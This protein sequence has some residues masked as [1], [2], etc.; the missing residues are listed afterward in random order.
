MI[1][2]AESVPRFDAE[3]DWQIAQTVP[4]SA[5]VLLKKI[6]PALACLLAGCG[7]Q[8]DPTLEQ[9]VEQTYKVEPTVNISVGNGDGSISI[10][11]ADTD[12]VSVEAT[13]R[14]YS[15]SRLNGIA[16][17]VST[18]PGFIAIETNFPPKP[19]WGLFD[20]SG[21]VDYV[22]IVPR[23]AKIS[24]LDLANGEILVEEMRGAPVQARLGSGRF[25]AHNCFCN[26]HVAVV[27]G[28]L[29]VIYDWWEETK[30]S[31]DANIADGNASVSLP[32]DASFHL[33]AE[34]PGGK[35]A[36]DFAE[37]EERNGSEV[38][39]IDKMIGAAPS[40]DIKI[41]A[42]DGNIQILERNP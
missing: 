23:T 27:R 32:D 34:A 18:Q 39:K 42:T 7:S 21:I 15:Q 30:F 10:Y 17:N 4:R 31:V 22:L 9:I 24:R 14:A 35:I 40:A 3:D 1:L 20:R 16:V 19:T 38:T 25:S 33:I 5:A 36:N 41:H 37:R 13:K 29:S 28:L 8:D 2:S 12:E 11:G 26:L 6:L